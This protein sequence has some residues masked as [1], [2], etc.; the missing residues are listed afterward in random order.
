MKTLA[1]LLVLFFSALA[2]AQT[3]LT[4]E[5]IANFQ[6]DLMLKELDLT[7]VQK[8]KVKEINWRYAKKQKTLI[9]KDGSIFGKIGT[10][11]EIKKSKNEELETVLTEDQFEYCEDELESQIR[12]FLRK[13]MTN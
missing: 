12:E 5:E 1:I 10:I 7:A 8:E 4:V 13:N 6:N 3:D 2:E 9:D 11:R